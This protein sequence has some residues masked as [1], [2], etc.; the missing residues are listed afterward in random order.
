MTHGCLDFMQSEGFF[1]L[2]FKLSRPEETLY[3]V[4]EIGETKGGNPKVGKRKVIVD[5][6]PS[7]G[8]KVNGL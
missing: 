2:G 4:R 1:E 6:C 8:E 5:F 3:F 7:C